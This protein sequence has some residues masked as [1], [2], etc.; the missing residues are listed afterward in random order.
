MYKHDQ[1]TLKTTQIFETI[2]FNN[3]ANGKSKK[4][5]V[6]QNGNGYLL[7]D[8]ENNSSFEGTYGKEENFN[9]LKLNMK[10]VLEG[11]KEIYFNSINNPEQSYR[12]VVRNFEFI[13]VQDQRM[14]NSSGGLLDISYSSLDENN[15]RN[16]KCS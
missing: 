8:L 2:E 6:Q 9:G 3:F 1:E 10:D 15:Y 5:L 12:E 16:T 14:F 7:T 4:Y 11:S 13:P